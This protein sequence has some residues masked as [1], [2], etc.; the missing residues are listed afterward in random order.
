MQ[1]YNQKAEVLAIML[2]AM[3]MLNEKL[4]SLLIKDHSSSKSGARDQTYLG[5]LFRDIPESSLPKVPF[6]LGR[7][8]FRSAAYYRFQVALSNNGR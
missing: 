5:R 6:V 4:D 3:R 2:P 1:I 7:T 8:V